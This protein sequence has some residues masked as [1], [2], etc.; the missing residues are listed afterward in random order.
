MEIRGV[1]S[2]EEFKGTMEL[3]T[4]LRSTFYDASYLYAAKSRKLKLVTE[5][6]ELKD[7]AE[8]ANIEAV[9][10]NRFLKEIG[11]DKPL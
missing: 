7:K 1:E 9:T 5:D 4:E 11:K 6:R 3:A 2:C 8:H 10:V